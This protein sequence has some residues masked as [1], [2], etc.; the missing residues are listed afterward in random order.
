MTI[1]LVHYAAAPIIGGVERII[2][3][4]ARLLSRHGHR[5]TILCQRGAGR[6]ITPET[7]CDELRSHDLAIVHNIF[8]MPFDLALTEALWQAAATIRTIAW[9]HDLAAANPD[10]APV[11]PILTKAAPGVEYVA[12]SALR[13]RQLRTT[14]G[15]E[16]ARIIPNGIDPIRILDLPQ[17]VAA[18]VEKER[19]FD[20]AH[21]FLHP[22]R[23][24]RRKNVETSIRLAQAIPN[25]RLI[26]TGADDSHN[27][28]S[29]D[30]AAAMR[31]LAGPETIFSSERF[32]VGDAEL[33]ALY[34]LADA[35]IFPSRQ[36][37]F[38]LPL[39]EARL[40]RL[41]A[42]Y[43]DIE[44]LAELA[45]DGFPISPDEAPEAIARRILPW[46]ATISDRRKVLA[47][48][49]WPAI[50]QRHIRPLIEKRPL[51]ETMNFGSSG[52][53]N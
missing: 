40:H 9:T 12:I 49:A 19:L 36:E 8:T 32:P 39:L 33:S 47:E 28:A 17:N 53:A 13:Q 31:R 10:L 42:I 37:G 1:A 26:I 38:G 45:G 51:T 2:D 5:V 52:F 48:Y 46:L 11:S 43:S 7:L 22:T 16:N 27:P 41:P 18:L 44:P 3:E 30:Y 15:I 24:L 20:A 29:A 50:Y 6:H 21:I 4:H 14:L 34:R 35:L 23:L 25:A